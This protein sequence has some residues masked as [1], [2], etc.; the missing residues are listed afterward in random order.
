MLKHLIL[1]LAFILWLATI[2]DQSLGNTIYFVWAIAYAFS[3][4][5]Y[6]LFFASEALLT[7]ISFYFIDTASDSY[8]LSTLLPWIFGFLAVVFVLMVA[9]KYLSHREIELDYDCDDY[10][11]DKSSPVG[12]IW[13]FF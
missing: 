10:H 1:F 7:S 12:R 8:F 13:F 4:Y 9:T 3:L 2:L 6:S 11:K 5:S